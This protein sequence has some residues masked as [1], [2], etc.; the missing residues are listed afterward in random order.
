MIRIT[1]NESPLSYKGSIVSIY[2]V[3]AKNFILNIITLFIYRSWAK[4]RIRRYLWSH[5]NI[6]G[7]PL[8]YTGT[9]KELFKGVVKVAF[10]YFFMSLIILAITLGITLKVGLEDI[11]VNQDATQQAIE[12]ALESCGYKDIS[13]LPDEQYKHCLLNRKLARSYHANMIHL[14][15][16]ALTWLIT[17][18]ILFYAQYSALRYRLSRTT[19]C[20]IHGSL[21]GSARNYAFMSMGRFI[22]NIVTLGLS[23]PKS[24]L[25]KQSVITNNMYLGNQKASFH[26]GRGR[27]RSVNI[28]TLLLAIPTLSFSRLWYLAELRNQKLANLSF[29]GVHFKGTFTGYNYLKLSVGNLLILIVT[30]GLGMPVILNRIINFNIKN[31]HVLGNINEL[32][33]SQADERTKVSNMGEGFKSSVDTDTGFD[34]DF[35]LI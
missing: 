3:W 4:T 33:I 18:Y 21:T 5:I 1:S 7:Q 29:G 23:I 19:W 35:G 24:D 15:S 6:N 16:S 32:T 28:R 25:I 34:V 11:Q 12:Q 13:A 22:I 17:L 14:F 31:M 26:E 30:L 10:F 8:I 9:G 20:G 2:K 27:L